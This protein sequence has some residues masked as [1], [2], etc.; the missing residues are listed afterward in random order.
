MW[1]GRL[2]LVNLAKTSPGCQALDRYARI[3]FLV[4]A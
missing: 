4:L 3:I 2:V 1:K